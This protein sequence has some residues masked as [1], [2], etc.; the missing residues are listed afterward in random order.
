MLKEK[1]QVSV[2]MRLLRQELR[3]ATAGL[4]QTSLARSPSRPRTM[5]HIA[6][7]SQRVIALAKPA[8]RP[9]GRETDLREDAFTVSPMALKAKCSKR[10]KN[11]AKPKTY[12]KPVF[13]R[14]RTALKR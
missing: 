5:R 4:K 1:R 10:L 3:K 12:P 2:I 8:K 9:E 14:L 13:K 7:S 11:L 6:L